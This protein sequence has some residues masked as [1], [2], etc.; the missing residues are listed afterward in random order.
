METSIIDWIGDTPTVS[1]NVSKQSK[2]RVYAKLEMYNPFGMKDRVAKNTILHA[3]KTGELKEGAPIIE[4]SSGTLAMGLALVGTYLEHDVHIVTDP[5]IDDVTYS[6]IKALGAHIHIVDKMGETG[7]WQKARL[8]YLNSLFDIYPE[9]FW[10]KQYENQQNPRAYYDLADNLIRDLGKVDVLIGSVGSGGSLSGTAERLKNYNR[11]LKVIAVDAIGSSIFFQKDR[12]KRLQ[13]GLGNSLQPENVKY[14]LI[15]EV[16]WLNDEEAFSWTHELA[17]QEKIFAGNSSGSVY[18]VANWMSQNTTSNQ[19]IAC[20]F[21]DR[22]DRYFNTIYNESFCHDHNL[23]TQVPNKQP[24]E[25]KYIRN[26]DEWAYIN[27]DK[28]RCLHEK[29]SFY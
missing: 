2:A 23:S 17:K 7:G 11:D 24:I 10:P 22:G 6:K 26:T 4:S 1:L 19:V 3:K 21:P 15:D 29:V 5:R 20:I 9:A 13:S 28:G 8:K 25:L 27:F 16:H 14:S 12:P 18:A